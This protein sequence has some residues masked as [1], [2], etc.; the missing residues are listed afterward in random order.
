MGYSGSFKMT[1]FRKVI[2]HGQFGDVS[3]GHDT[4]SLSPYHAISVYDVLMY[5]LSGGNLP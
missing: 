4:K 1:L 3:V 2:Y 5:R